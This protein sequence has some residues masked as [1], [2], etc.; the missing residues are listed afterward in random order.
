MLN[1]IGK[2]IK[3]IYTLMMAVILVLLF[4]FS[5]LD[6]ICKVKFS[7][8]NLIL[9][10][11]SLTF[12]LMAAVIFVMVKKKCHKE[13]N[14]P[15][16]RIVQVSA[17]LLFLWQIYLSY[18]IYF[19]T[20]WDA[21][22]V[23][24]NAQ[25]LAFGESAQLSHA[26]FSQYPN[27]LFIVS[28]YALIL[29]LN[30]V[31]G[32]FSGSRQIMSLIIVNCMC[33]TLACILIYRVLLRLLD[34]GYAFIGFWL[35]V[36]AFGLSPW[37]TICYSDALGIWVPILLFWL[38]LIPVKSRRFQIFRYF[39]MILLGIIGYAIKPQTI[40]P[41]IAVI[42]V[43]LFSQM[44]QRDIKKLMVTGM[45]LVLALA[46]AA[47]ASAGLEKIYRK[48]GFVLDKE[49]AYGMAHFLMM[50][51]NEERN[52]V[53]AAEDVE[54]SASFAT[55]KERQSAN[56]E[57]VKQ[58]LKDFGVVGYG[59]HL[60]KKLLVNYHDGTYAWGNEGG[61]FLEYYPEPDTKAAV[62]LRNIYYPTGQNYNRWTTVSQAVWLLVLFLGFC[63]GIGDYKGENQKYAG[64]L[65]LSIIGLTAFV[66]LFEARARYL[67]T[68]IPVFCVLA[69]MGLYTLKKKALQ[70]GEDN[71]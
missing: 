58:R 36:A 68:H 12:L 10:A 4:F 55:R 66:L 59:R 41:L 14:I 9:F 6:Y 22:L 38:Y 67:Y 5:D 32:I 24:S 23:F 42:G 69:V 54:F 45:S 62:I 43:E 18:N 34:E 52:G 16:G 33:S 40:I 50:G 47:A 19:N 65:F 35:G 70:K 26:Y 53:W 39:A 21:G 15:Y 7:F 1:I 30:S 56:L 20:G 71:G 61:F 64:I 63:A 3:W 29:K 46:L 60:A 25:T 48:E 8:S 28:V 17:I 13:I 37:V 51:M 49:A 11:G 2:C 44:T 31:L 27:N 57:V